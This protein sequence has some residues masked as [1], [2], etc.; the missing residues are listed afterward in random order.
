MQGVLAEI[1]ATTAEETD[2]CWWW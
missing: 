2:S 1:T